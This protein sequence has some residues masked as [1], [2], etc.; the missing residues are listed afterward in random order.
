MVLYKCSRP[1]SK[2]IL[3][4]FGY[5][6]NFC[7]FSVVLTSFDFCRLFIYVHLHPPK[8]RTNV[9]GH[10]FLRLKNLL[11]LN[12]NDVLLRKMCYFTMQ[13]LCEEKQYWHQQIGIKSS[14]FFLV[15]KKLCIAIWSCM[16]LENVM[17]VLTLLV[18]QTFVDQ[19]FKIWGCE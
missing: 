10:I 18:P 2:I 7:K 19:F 3:P 17:Q 6:S 12:V 16:L 4:Y 8:V 11:F 14:I 9:F 1:M 13:S 15:F 5:Q